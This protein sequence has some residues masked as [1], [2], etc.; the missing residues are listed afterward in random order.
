M[1]RPQTTASI[2]AKSVLTGLGIALVVVGFVV[3]A[4]GYQSIFDTQPT[5][6]ARAEFGSWLLI[7]GSL[8]LL[9][10]V[11]AWLITPGVWDLVAPFIVGLMLGLA[12]IASLVLSA[13]FTLTGR[14]SLIDPS[15][16]VPW[17]IGLSIGVTA[18]GFAQFVVAQA[19][20]G[21]EP[22]VRESAVWRLRASAASILLLGMIAAWTS[23]IQLVAVLTMTS[24]VYI[25]IELTPRGN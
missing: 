2:L 8:W 18:I 11:T 16:G 4:T 3:R 1:T 6:P 21:R 10:S 23:P 25:A 7:V 12:I 17:R 14:P 19:L 24:L 13:A 9:I 5:D 22:P 20:R 15:E